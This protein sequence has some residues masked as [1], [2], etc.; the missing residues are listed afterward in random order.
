MIPGCLPTRCKPW[1]K[2]I[3]P[4]TTQGQVACLACVACSSCRSRT[5]LSPCSPRS[6]PARHWVRP[7]PPAPDADAAC[8]CPSA[9][10]P[11]SVEGGGGGFEGLARV[12][13]GEGSCGEGTCEEP[14]GR[15]WSSFWRWSPSL[16][17]WPLLTVQPAPE[18]RQPDPPNLCH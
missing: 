2:S 8:H 11:C 7:G 14:H 18:D 15:Y 9:A 1:G 3:P 6:W 10:Q 17:L 4:E 16:C 13:G 5:G 12:R